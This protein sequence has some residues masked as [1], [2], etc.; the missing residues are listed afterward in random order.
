MKPLPSGLQ[1]H[2]D[3]A[4]TTLC[5]CWRLTRRDGTTQGFTDHDRDLTFD[6][7]VFEAAAGFTASEVRDTLG[8]SVDNLEVTGAVSSQHLEEAD[9][10]S[11]LYDDAYVEIFRVNWSDPA[12]RVL[13]RSGSLGEVKRNGLAFS[14][15]IRGL[16]HYLQQPNGRLYQYT[17][18]ADLGDSRC[19]VNLNTA[20]YRDTG[21]IAA[22][23]DDRTFTASG[24]SGFASGWFSRGLIAFT[25]GAAAGQSV[26]VRQHTK[27]AGVVTVEL[28]QPVRLPLAAGQTFTIKAGCNKHLDTCR[29]KFGNAVNFRG[30]PH[31][32]GND[33]LTAVSR[34]GSKAR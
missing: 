3:S 29:V 23:I 8:L 33:F 5:W 21:S 17:C 22:A 19:T 4:T 12:Q 25:S 13:M 24:L 1:A 27:A 6:S 7:T 2:L 34:P 18:D 10:E 15:E 28:W 31:M 11:G 26:E 20:Q 14:A 30:F 32:P 9:L 16:A